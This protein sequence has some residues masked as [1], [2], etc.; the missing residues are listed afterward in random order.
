MKG[1]ETDNATML[2]YGLNGRYPGVHAFSTTRRGGCSTGSYATMN[3]NPWTGD[4]PA[5]VAENLRRLEQRVPAEVALWVMPHQT[6]STRVHVI[7]AEEVSS[8]L[9]AATQRPAVYS[10][11]DVDAVV[12]DQSGVCLCISTADCIPVLLYDRRTQAIAAIH[13]GWRGT[14]GRIIERTIDVMAQQYGTQGS[15]LTACIGPGISK[16]AFEVGDEVYEAFRTAGFPM[17]R[18]AERR[19]KWHLDLWEANRLQLLHRGVPE[20]QIEVAGICTYQ[21][22]GEFFSARRLGIQSGRILTGI[23]RSYI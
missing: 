1:Q 8:S 13:A 2:G 9:E 12:T 5:C 17:E 15:D 19:A 22:D 7:S 3:V 14:V 23:C 18:I 4:E 11:E 16:D 6:H 21:R 10:P 20:A